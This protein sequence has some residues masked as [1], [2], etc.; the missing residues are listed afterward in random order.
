MS[1]AERSSSIVSRIKT[2]LIYHR[3]YAD[4]PTRSELAISQLTDDGLPLVPPPILPLE[5]NR[6]VSK[7]D[8]NNVQEPIQSPAFAASPNL[9]KVR[10]VCISDTHNASPLDGVFHVPPGDVL[11][12]AGDMTNQGSYS[13]LKKVA[14]WLKSQP[15]EIKLI[16][17]GNHD[18]VT[19]DHSFLV[20]YAN[21]FKWP[22]IQSHAENV[23][24]FTS[25]EARAAGIVY[26]CHQSQ[27]ITLRDGRRF[28]VFG[29]PWSPKHG[30][31]GFGYEPA[32]SLEQSVWKDIPANTDVLITHGPPKFH[33]DS[34]PT[35][36]P[37]VHGGCELL[38]Q[39]VW[40]VRPKLHVFGHIHEGHGV[41]RVI[42]DTRSK[43][44]KYRA[45]SIRQVEDIMPQGRRQFIVDLVR[46]KLQDG[47]ETCMVNAAV[48]G[49][50]KRFSK[51]QTKYWQKAVVVDLELPSFGIEQDGKG[52]PRMVRVR[53]MEDSWNS[54]TTAEPTNRHTS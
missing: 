3:M 27:T 39:Q 36:I 7:V 11:I 46:D 54:I 32:N 13:E 40:T 51:G 48:A 25:S 1:V 41:E 10:F 38:R 12:H 9:K 5:S 49:G 34:S 2:H 18:G 16:I 43:F 6:V 26:L 37:P 35:V 53:G 28:T 21:Y 44:V 33:L 22:T 19:L 45:T 42:W 30:L 23:Q 47:M 50:S 4:P 20:N 52:E 17:A 15:H 29:S 24:L 8:G 31:W 14:E